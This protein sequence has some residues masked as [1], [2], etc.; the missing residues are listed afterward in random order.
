M[1]PTDDKVVE[2]VDMCVICRQG[3]KRGSLVFVSNKA[4]HHSCYAAF[5]EKS[6]TVRPS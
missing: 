4:Y 2:F 5:G 1:V 3:I 6:G